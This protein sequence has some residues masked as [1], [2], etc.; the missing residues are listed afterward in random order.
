MLPDLRTHMLQAYNLTLPQWRRFDAD[1]FYTLDTRLFNRPLPSEVGQLC[2]ARYSGRF[3]LSRSSIGDVVE[4]VGN[5]EPF[6]VSNL[7][8][9]R[10]L[11]PD[12]NH[13]QP[14]GVRHSTAS[15]TSNLTTHRCIGRWISS[16]STWIET[17]AQDPSGCTTG[18]TGS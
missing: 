3:H 12:P 5:S 1:S 8:D 17:S 9:F 13:A 6:P 11:C 15:S 4:L 14:L 2:F 10:G 16:E 18:W 7:I